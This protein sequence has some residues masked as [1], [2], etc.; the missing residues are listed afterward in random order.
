MGTAVG[1]TLAFVAIEAIAGWRAHS[2][3]LMSDAGHNFADA[4]AL[5]LS[6]YAMV[7]ARRRATTTMTFGYHRVGVLA[8]MVNAASLVMI[9][10]IIFWEAFGRFRHPEAVDPTIMI[11]VAAIAVVLNTAISMSLHKGSDDLNIR[12]AYL[13]MVGDAVSAG[14][15]VV[16][17]VVVR[18]TGAHKAD[19]VV[20]VLI[21]LLILW[22]S[23]GILR[24]CLNVLLEGV[25]ADL[26]VDAIESAL[27]GIPNV[28][29]VHHVHAWTIS[30][31]FLACSC[32][33]VPLVAGVEG[34]QHILEQAQ[35]VL[36]SKFDFHHTTIQVESVPCAAPV[37]GCGPATLAKHE[38]H[39]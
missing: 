16:A 22:S 28:G 38:D 3:A 2:L 21:A 7:I 6:W 24:E 17:G 4:A 9:A 30:S 37:H 32:H 1:L 39:S 36:E 27:R 33:I 31:G 29:D 5:G 23:W 34:Q 10:V 19:P 20:S 15:V 14:G 11:A 18:L 25:P 26:N 8:A 35:R 13:H 12:S